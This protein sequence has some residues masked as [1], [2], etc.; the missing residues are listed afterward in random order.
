[1]FSFLASLAFR[2]P[3]TVVAAAVAL[4]A[5]A[6]ILGGSVAGR[7]APYEAKDPATESI[8][9]ERLLRDVG[10]TADVDAVVLV[11]P[12]A[13][14]TSRRGRARIG[15]VV[16]ALRADPDVARVIGALD[17]G[18][19]FVSR[20]GRSIFVGASFRPR[21]VRADVVERLPRVLG[22]RP[23]VT[24]GGRAVAE[25]QV[26]DQVER[27]LRR[28]EALAFPLLFVLSFLFFRS[29]VAAALP[30]LV[31]GLAILLTFLGLRLANGL[32]PVS[33]FALNLVTGLGL[34]LALDYSLL[35]VSRYR[36]ELARHG[37]GFEALRR[38][39]AT[40]GRTVLF[41]SLT[42]T[43]AVA[44]LLVFPQ[45]FLVSMAVGGIVV[46][47]VAASAALI[48]LPAVLALLGPSVDALAPA[49]LQRA[50][51][52]DARPARSGAWYRLS[53]VVM[54]APWR[55]AIVSAAVLVALG[56]PFLGIRFTSIDASVLPRDAG[57]R[58]VSDAL[59]RDFG[60]REANPIY[61]VVESP[62]PD[63]ARRLARAATTLP[64]VRLVTP[65]RPVGG[66]LWVVDVF[67]AADA[68]SASSQDLVRHMRALDPGAPTQVGGFTAQFVDLKA[69]L[70]RHMPVAGAVIVLATLVVLF[71]MTGSV[72]LPV[73][74]LVMNVLTLSA[75]FGILV[76]VFQDGRSKGSSATRAR[77]ARVHPADRLFAVAFGLSTDYGVFLL[78]RIKEAHDGGV[79]DG[80]DVAVGL[81][82]TGRIVTAA[83]LLFSVAVSAFA[84]SEII[85]IKEVGLGIAL[86]VLIDATIVRALLVPSLMALLGRRNWWAP[87]PLLRLRDRLGFAA[88]PM[89]S[90]P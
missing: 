64:G 54:R 52:R 79:P 74:S 68:L 84:T 4:A 80:E 22:D 85:F 18:P 31:G 61:A 5:V 7:L 53:R 37:P 76:L 50:A 56:L 1:V 83:A 60:R 28:A 46:S 21:A 3:R 40:A 82:R 25:V 87:R 2:R 55:V 30:L 86:A 8:R 15:A 57:A 62:S 39:L 48:V 44:A 71:L 78:S 36:E 29:L 47:V 10:A 32:W 69:S 70:V 41:S 77:G 88:E 19:A 17:G 34:G 67:P 33:V 45:R 43:A 12:G 75:A 90:R 66:G 26:A 9:A 24:L 49:R 35:L 89:V 81:E 6:A 13:P 59:E 65:A 11:R 38:T 14:V 16:A 27:D 23:D 63:I 58:Q 72:V 20:D 73:K 42:I 51:E